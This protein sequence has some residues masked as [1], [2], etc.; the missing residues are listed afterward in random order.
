M[1]KSLDDIGIQ[2]VKTSVAKTCICPGCG[3]EQPF[4]RDREYLKKVKDLSLIFT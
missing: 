2:V 1:E 4:L 3:I